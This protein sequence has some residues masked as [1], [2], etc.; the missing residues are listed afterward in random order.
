MADKFLF[1]AYRYSLIICRSKANK[2][3][4][5]E[6]KTGKWW[7]PGGKVETSETF[8]QAALR[9]CQEETGIQVQLK[10]IIRLDY[11]KFADK[12]AWRTVYYA[13]PIEDTLSDLKTK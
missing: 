3:L 10:G 12:N 4:T 2:F 1:P 5:V 6:E 8:E 9:E 13:E 7:I 11:G